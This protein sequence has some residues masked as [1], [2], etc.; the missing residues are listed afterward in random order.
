MGERKPRVWFVCDICGKR[1]SENPSQARKRL[2]RPN[3]NKTQC[4][5]MPCR[6]KSLA[7]AK[8]KKRRKRQP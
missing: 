1:F 2:N 3:G 8:S 7:L 5:S 4:C 6:D